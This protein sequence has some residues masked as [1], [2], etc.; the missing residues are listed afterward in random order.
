MVDISYIFCL[1]FKLFS[2]GISI[3]IKDLNQQL[4]LSLFWLLVLHPTIRLLQYIWG[5]MAYQSWC[6]N[7]DNV[8][9]ICSKL[10]VRL[11]YYMNLGYGKIILSQKSRGNWTRCIQTVSR[12][13]YP[14]IRA[15]TECWIMLRLNLSIYYNKLLTLCFVQSELIQFNTIELPRIVCSINQN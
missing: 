13:V 11:S 15:L 8:V 2:L 6:I 7:H 3:L 10:L 14:E 12:L 4:L 1:H 5:Q 9:I